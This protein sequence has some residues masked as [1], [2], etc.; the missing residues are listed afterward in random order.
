MRARKVLR[1]LPR[2]IICLFEFLS[3]R[4]FKVIVKVRLKFKLLST[5]KIAS[6]HLLT[7]N[8]KNVG[9][10][11]LKN[12]VV[13]LHSPDLGF[14]VDCAGCFVYAL[15]PSAD[16]NVKFRVSVSSLARAYFSVCGYASGDTYFSIESPVM[17]VQTKDS[18][19]N[20]MLLM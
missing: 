7:L 18:M 10:S 5:T 14:S 19:E 17:A 11:I 8:L 2:N 16:E 20:S 15:M 9:S 3:I 13:R 1:A 12:L 6:D 4:R